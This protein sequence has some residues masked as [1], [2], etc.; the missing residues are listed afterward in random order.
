VSLREYQPA[1]RDQCIQIY[2]NNEQ[3]HFPSGFIDQFE[4]FLDGGDALKL[5]IC[6]DGAVE[7]LGGINRLPDQ[8]GECAWL[9]FGMVNPAWQRQ[10]LGTLLTLARL[11]VLAKPV[12]SIRIFMANVPTSVSFYERFGFR[13]SGMLRTVH[14][15]VKLPG[16]TTRFDAAAWQACRARLTD[17]G[18][19]IPSVVVPL[20][21]PGMMRVQRTR[22]VDRIPLD[23]KE[24]VLEQYDYDMIRFSDSSGVFVARQYLSEREAASFLCAESRGERRLLTRADLQ[25][26]LFCEAVRYLHAHGV[27]RVQWLNPEGERYEVVPE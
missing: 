11:G 5:V 19:S 20:L 4:A 12:R 23:L 3:T 27:T 25:T 2:R 7:G 13:S 6:L 18:I 9:S 26:R 10:G 16:N 1:D 8:G 24:P 21:R 22:H 17:L 15:S 14:R